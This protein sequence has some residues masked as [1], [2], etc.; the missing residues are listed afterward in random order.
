MESVLSES[1]IIDSADV[2]PNIAVQPH[3]LQQE[4]ALIN[5]NI[6]NVIV[7]QVNAFFF[8]LTVYLGFFKSLLNLS[9]P[10]KTADTWRGHHWFPREMTSEEWA[11]KF[12]SD[13]ASLPRSGWC[14][15]LV[16]PRGKFALTYQKYYSDLGNDTS[17][18][19][20]FCARSSDVISRG[21]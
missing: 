7:E 14:F 1:V 21:N 9:A 10:E 13:D 5:V 18:V 2:L 11:Q 8:S 17:S 3:T 6:P 20:N 12:H 19:W 16:V 15:W 4:F